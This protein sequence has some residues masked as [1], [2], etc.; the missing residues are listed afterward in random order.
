[1]GPTHLIGVHTY[2]ILANPLYLDDFQYFSADLEDR[3]KRI[4]DDDDDEANDNA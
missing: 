1:M 3:S 2:D 4:V